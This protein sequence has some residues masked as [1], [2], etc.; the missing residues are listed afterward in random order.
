[1]K[2]IAIH[3]ASRVDGQ[4]LQGGWAS[5]I[6]NGKASREF[7]GILPST[8]ADHLALAALLNALQHL[9]HLPASTTFNIESTNAHLC[10]GVAGEVDRWR[11]RGWRQL[12]GRRVPHVVLWKGIYKL[13]SRFDGCVTHTPS[14]QFSSL[15]ARAVHLC[16][17]QACE[18]GHVSIYSDASYFPNK[19]IGG[20]GAV[21]DDSERVLNCSGAFP[22]A[23]NNAAELVAAVQALEQ[24]DGKKPVLLYTDSEY[25]A[26]GV[27]NLP[28]WKAGGWR[29]PMSGQ[30]VANRDLWQRLDS[31]VT[32]LKVRVEW[33]KGHSGVA[34]NVK[35]DKLAGRAAR[36]AL[37]AAGQ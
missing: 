4:N 33:V 26:E 5:V 9:T 11:A 30:P 23:D 6:Y 27:Q 13:L 2:S 17:G 31:L 15:L 34:G 29:Y 32:R 14:P 21:I 20:W 24:I 22:A 8:D 28:T 18:P 25:V 10:E 1:M 16:G 12:N 37:Q 35:A 3:V 36:R 7:S 19:K